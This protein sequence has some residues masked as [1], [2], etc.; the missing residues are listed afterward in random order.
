[1]NEN[2]LLGSS[3]S[4]CNGMWNFYKLGRIAFKEKDFIKDMVI[5]SRQHDKLFKQT[6]ILFLFKVHQLSA[7]SSAL[8]REKEKVAILK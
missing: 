4:N 1:M 3:S 5:F 8:L 6:P 7:S 2:W